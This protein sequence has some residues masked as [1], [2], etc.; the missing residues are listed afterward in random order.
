VREACTARG[1]TVTGFVERALAF[2]AEHGIGGKRLMTD[3]AFSNYAH[4]AN[5]A[6]GG[7]PP[8]A[9]PSVDQ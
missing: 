4:S 6:K 7:P 3:N 5:L 1:G 2:Y 9:L 8:E